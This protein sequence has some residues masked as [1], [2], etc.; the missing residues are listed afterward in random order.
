MG[1]CLIH[2]SLNKANEI[3]KFYL[4]EF[5]FLTPSRLRNDSTDIKKDK[6]S[7]GRVNYKRKE[8]WL[9]TTSNPDLHFSLNQCTRN[10]G[11]KKRKKEIIG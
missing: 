7:P 3:F 6:T 11:E 5:C 2:D 10:Y 9:E 4:F 1:C 8:F